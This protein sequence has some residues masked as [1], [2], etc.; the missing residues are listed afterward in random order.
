MQVIQIQ[1]AS[2][3]LS[4][5]PPTKLEKRHDDFHQARHAKYY[6]ISDLKRIGKH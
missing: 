4:M 3:N 2:P 1:D 5:K 6:I